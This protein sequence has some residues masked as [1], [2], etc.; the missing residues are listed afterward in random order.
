M[1]KIRKYLFT[2]IMKKAILY[3][4]DK[5][6]LQIIFCV[7][8]FI[9][10]VTCVFVRNNVLD[11]ICFI[12]FSFTL[13]LL[14]VSA[15]YHGI[16]R[17]WRKVILT[18]FLFCG[19]IGVFIFYSFILLFGRSD[20][21]EE[22]GS[23]YTFVHEGDNYNYIFHGNNG[24]VIDPNV[25]SF[26]YNKQFIIVKQQPMPFQYAYETAKEYACR[27]DTIAFCYWLILKEEQKVLGP[28]DSIQFLKLRKD[29]RVHEKLK[30]K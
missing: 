28:L 6:C 13:F 1:V 14:V 11:N 12:I 19:Y 7:F 27:T 15:I 26:E 30:F 4:F 3:I 5:W 9:L 17:K 16:K 22:L 24:G 21:T 23:G 25:V 10:F 18:F 20:Y 29:Y 2:K 8:T